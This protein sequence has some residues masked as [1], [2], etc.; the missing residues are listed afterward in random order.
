MLPKG[1]NRWFVTSPLGIGLMLPILLTITPASA[2]GQDEK[3]K[4]KWQLPVIVFPNVPIH[5]H[6]LP[7]GKVL[8]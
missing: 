1:C 7:N 2:Q 4:G 5:T 3:T 6:V 8:F